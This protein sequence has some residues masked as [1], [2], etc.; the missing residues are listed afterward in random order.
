TVH[1]DEKSRVGA[2]YAALVRNDL[3]S[4]DWRTSSRAVALQAPLTNEVAVPA[5]IEA[6]SIWKARAA[7]GAQSLRVRFELQRA[8]RARSGRVFGLEPEEWRV[9]WAH[10]RAGGRGVAPQ[11]G[12]VPQES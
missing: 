7:A 10:M 4:D 3:V 5:L 8:L 6:L 12:A 11:S 2:D 1:F 9:W